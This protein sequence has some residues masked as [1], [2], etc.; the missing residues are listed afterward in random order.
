MEKGNGNLNFFLKKAISIGILM[1]CI[2]ISLNLN[3]SL[4]AE[5]S[6]DFGVGVDCTYVLSPESESTQGHGDSFKYRFYPY[7]AISSN[8]PIGV[9]SVQFQQGFIENGL[10]EVHIDGEPVTLYKSERL[11]DSTGTQ[12]EYAP[13]DFSSPEDFSFEIFFYTDFYY[14]KTITL[15]HKH[16]T[17][18]LRD[19]SWDLLVQ[20]P[21]CREMLTVI[22]RN[23]VSRKRSQDH[24]DIRELSLPYEGTSS[25]VI[26]IKSNEGSYA[27]DR[28]EWVADGSPWI[29][30]Q[31]SN[32][33][34]GDGTIHFHVD[35]NPE[36]RSRTGFVSIYL[37]E[38]DTLLDREIISQADKTLSGI[39]INYPDDVFY[40]DNEIPYM[41]ETKGI[42]NTLDN[43]VLFTITA[44]F[45]CDTDNPPFENCAESV[46]LDRD[47]TLRWHIDSPD[48]AKIYSDGKLTAKS[49]NI[50]KDET[51]NVKAIY[52][53]MNQ[54]REKT[55]PR[56]DS[57]PLGIKDITELDRIEIKSKA[58]PFIY[59]NTRVTEFYVLATFSNQ[60]Y[61]VDITNKVDWDINSDRAEISQNGLLATKSV[62]DD[63]EIV[64]KASYSLRGKTKEDDILV[65]IYDNTEL[66]Q[67][68]IVGEDSIRPNSESEYRVIAYYTN[69]PRTD[70][71]DQ[72]QVNL[73]AKD[74]EY[75]DYE[76][77]DGKIIIETKDIKSDQ[78][79]RLQV[80]YE[81]KN[82]ELRDFK[83]I[84][85]TGGTKWQVVVDP[86]SYTV[87]EGK[88][89]SLSAI[90]KI[91]DQA[92]KDISD[93][94]TWSLDKD[95]LEYA[96]IVDNNLVAK[97]LDNGDKIVSVSAC[98]E[99]ESKE[100]CDQQ[101]ITIVDVTQL[102]LEI[103]GPI[104]IN[105]GESIDITANAIWSNEGEIIVTGTCVWE[106][107]NN[108]I[109]L[110]SVNSN[111]AQI[112]A[113]DIDKNTS[114]TIRAHYADKGRS[115]SSSKSIIIKKLPEIVD[116]VIEGPKVV[117]E[118][119]VDNQ[120]KAIFKYD[121]FESRVVTD[122]CEWRLDDQNYEFAN[123]DNQGVL[124]TNS[125][126]WDQT[127]NVTAEYSSSTIKK[128]ATFPVLIKDV[129]LPFDIKGDITFKENVEGIL[130]VKGCP[131]SDAACITPADI[132][133]VEWENTGAEYTV[134]YDE[135]S[136]FDKGTPI[137]VNHDAPNN[138]QLQMNTES[139]PFPFIVVACSDRGTAVRV[140]TV[141]GEVIGEYLTSPDGRGKNPS[142][143]TVDLEGNV[144]IG[145]RNEAD[146]KGSVIKIGLI[147]GGSRYNQ[148]GEPDSEGEYIKVDDSVHYNTCI[149]RDGDGYIKTSIGLGNILSWNNA[150]GLDTDGGVD[151]AE[152]EAI[153]MYVRVNG[154]NVRHVSID[155]N[156]N[157]WVGGYENQ[158]FDL[159]NGKTGSILA[160][161]DVDRGGYGGLIDSHGVLWS[162][163]RKT[164]VG[165]LRYDTKNTV[166]TGDD[167]HLFIKTPDAYGLSI[168]TNGNIWFAQAHQNNVYKVAPDGTIF[169][170]FPKDSGGGGCTRG[171]AVTPADKHV[172]IANSHTGDSNEIGEVCRLDNDGNFIKFI[173]VGKSPT[174]VAVDSNG[175]VWVSNRNSNSLMRINPEG[176]DDQLGAVDLEV[177][178]G[179]GARPYNYSDMTGIIAMDTALQGTWNVIH[180]SEN[181][182]AKWLRIKWSSE[183]PEGTRIQVSIKAANA[184]ADLNNQ[185]FIEISNESDL[186]DITGKYLEIQVRFNRDND[187][188]LSPILYDLTVIEQ[189]MNSMPYELEVYDSAKY[190]VIAFIDID[191]DQKQDACEPQG[192]YPEVISE[193]NLDADFPLT[194]TD[195]CPDAG[196]SIDMY[197]SGSDNYIQDSV[198][199]QGIEKTTA[200]V[201]N[202]G[203][204]I[205]IGV[206][207]QN[208]TNLDTFQYDIVYDPEHLLYRGA[209]EKDNQGTSTS[210][211]N[212]NGGSTIFPPPDY[213]S[214][215]IR[216][217]NSLIGKDCDVAPE[218]TGLITF[219]SFEVIAAFEETHIDI[220]KVTFQ[221]D[222]ETKV[223]SIENIKEGIVLGEIP[224]CILKSDFNGDDYVDY[225]DLNLFAN[226][227]LY[228]NN[229]EE[230]SVCSVCNVDDTPDI[231][232]PSLQVIN[233]MDLNIFASEWLLKCTTETN[234]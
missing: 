31:S 81:F 215:K 106:I 202:Q 30:F 213:S 192:Q 27:E 199:N 180:S 37:T 95:S 43:F 53:Y 194:I 190:N 128:S 154:L 12:F 118:R 38:N 227:W 7:K 223:E 231:F 183:E 171:V 222:C 221:N 121:N 75:A 4:K 21:S 200:R 71:T 19:L 226:C 193:Q 64:I 22:T 174:G 51:I 28:C 209:F 33:G 44:Y 90:Q 62:E 78:V 216:I 114:V 109:A 54:E 29:K 201:M 198:S 145:N 184:Q 224:P 136:D 233:Y 112:Q 178:L 188:N 163:S 48:Y 155:K 72:V 168:D 225:Q 68:I 166:E 97:M 229:D 46:I 103:L 151:T 116:F 143:T 131:T 80:V 83:E 218:G 177:D 159:L 126:Y 197:L 14:E 214:G 74:Y 107:S 219:L 94:V 205:Y 123:I 160:T 147:V 156:N 161:F 127:V 187:V 3:G 142:R 32:S 76:Q 50:H 2:F 185:Q 24:T 210:L 85:I 138:N 153:L 69:E 20:C 104:T 92:D 47:P 70:V 11:N 146:G 148:D 176:G 60:K 165:L 172:W 181:L 208:V 228:S 150:E 101:Q 120:F 82:K 117:D 108:Q 204:T 173:K 40:Q 135:D 9:F 119:T 196:I 93:L 65:T 42:Y 139:K 25:G 45:N 39:E 79:I 129:P 91:E 110:L 1:I 49:E 56:E 63:T 134:V 234:R 52:Y 152:D 230:W 10:I 6:T 232:D 15:K 189:T 113:A 5:D 179:S 41:N 89:I 191:G 100:K 36:G 26:Y 212:K 59:E 67:I 73:D 220:E 175:F 84:T 195:N 217:A 130:T 140:N 86:E 17:I 18:N 162:S 35:K 170:G 124:S 167:E 98:Y 133:Q 141:T 164:A 182:D 207:A 111:K 203:E 186:E 115:A 96:S 8:A 122:E 34:S 57:K 206:V 149:D 99:F 87:E 158:V 55:A 23:E 105:E 137:N 61:S 13:E 102:A 88:T 66:D 77:Q 16:G 157:V 125:I 144:W 58:A 132:Y 211:L 169:D